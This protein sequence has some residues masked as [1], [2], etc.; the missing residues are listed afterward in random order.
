MEGVKILILNSCEEM[1]RQASINF[2]N[3]GGL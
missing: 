3:A 2:Q 1:G